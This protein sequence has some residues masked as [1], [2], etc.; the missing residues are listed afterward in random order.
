MMDWSSQAS[1]RAEGES[2]EE[3]Q[4]LRPLAAPNGARIERRCEQTRLFDSG[5]N[6]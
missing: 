3:G 2:V 6:G 4:S 5:R 1:R